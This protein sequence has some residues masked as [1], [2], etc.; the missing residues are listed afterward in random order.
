MNT[1]VRMAAIGIRIELVVVSRIPRTPAPW[2]YGDR[3]VIRGPKPSTTMIPITMSRNDDTT[4]DFLL[5]SLASSATT[6]T[7]VSSS[8]TAEVSAAKMTSR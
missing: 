8:E 2:S 5:L 1:H 6:E 3:S 7:T 4:M